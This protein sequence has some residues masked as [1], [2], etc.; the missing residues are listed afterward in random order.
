MS[1]SEQL[2]YAE[3]NEVIDKCINGIT[4]IINDADKLIM[5]LNN[6]IIKSKSKILNK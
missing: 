6:E 4:E 3:C 5:E 2:I 1:D